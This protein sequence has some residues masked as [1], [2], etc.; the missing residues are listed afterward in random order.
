MKTRQLF[1]LLSLLLLA[2]C[3]DEN[4]SHTSAVAPVEQAGDA[5]EG[6][7]GFKDKARSVEGVLEASAAE[8][9]SAIDAME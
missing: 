2:A 3:S 8:R 4:Q 5:W 7:A 9:Q 6:P 1:G